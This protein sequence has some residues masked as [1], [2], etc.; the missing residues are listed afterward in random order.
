MSRR[1]KSRGLAFGDHHILIGPYVKANSP[2][3]HGRVADVDV[4]IHGDADLCE[5]SSEARRG[6]QSA[7]YFRGCRV[8]HFDYTIGLPAP[9]DLIMESYVEHRRIATI[10]AQIFVDDLLSSRVLDFAA[11]ARRKLTHQSSVNRIA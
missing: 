8:T 9:A 4:F 2:V 1:I 7:P 10:I 5:T 11:L 3:D 6:V